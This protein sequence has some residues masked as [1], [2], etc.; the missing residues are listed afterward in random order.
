MK[1]SMKI[2]QKLEQLSKIG[3]A[4]VRGLDQSCKIAGAFCR[5]L[6]RLAPVFVEVFALL[7]LLHQLWQHTW[8]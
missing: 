5:F 2:D 1:G 8:T 7:A 3:P 4:I 6:R